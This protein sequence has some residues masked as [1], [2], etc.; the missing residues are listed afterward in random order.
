MYIKNRNHMRLGFWDREWDRQNFLLFWVILCT[1]NPPHN[2]ENQILKKWKKHLEISSFYTHVLKITIIWCMLPDIWSATDIFFFCHFARYFALFTPLLSP[3][4]KI[5]KK[6]KRAWRYDMHNINDNHMIYGSWD[7]Q[8][9][10]DYILMHMVNLFLLKILDIFFKKINWQ[11]L[12]W[13][14]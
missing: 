5:W 13:L 7:I 6:S 11:H 4:I 9:E 3:K 1:F 14:R 8:T 10:A 2:L 12:K